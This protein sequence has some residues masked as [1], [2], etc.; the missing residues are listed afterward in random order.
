MIFRW[1]R[2][3]VLRLRH[4][5]RRIRPTAEIGVADIG[6][7]QDTVY[8]QLSGVGGS[9]DGWFAR[10]PRPKVERDGDG[11]MEMLYEPKER[12]PIYQNSLRSLEI[13]GEDSRAGSICVSPDG[14][15]VHYVLQ[16]KH[17]LVTNGKTEELHLREQ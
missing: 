13:L 1:Q 17:W 8:L 2:T 16:D 4:L 14:T 12:L 6:V 3:G 15:R 11:A 10:L 7:S 9:G 5:R